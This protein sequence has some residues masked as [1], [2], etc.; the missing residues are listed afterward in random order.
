MI[1]HFGCQPAQSILIS[2]Q[3]V[4]LHFL[5]F[6]LLKKKSQGVRFSFTVLIKSDL[7]FWCF[8]CSASLQRRIIVCALLWHPKSLS[9]WGTAPKFVCSRGGA[10]SV[11]FLGCKPTPRPGCTHPGTFWGVSF[12]SWSSARW[13]ISCRAEI[14]AATWTGLFVAVSAISECRRPT[15]SAFC[16]AYS[17]Y[18]ADVCASAGWFSLLW[19]FSSCCS[20]TKAC[21]GFFIVWSLCIVEPGK[22]PV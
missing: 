6:V 12:P 2:M 17:Q 21:A 19:F 8:R 20:K 4:M 5:S 11:R 18:Q 7:R 14:F 9:G 10:L 13:W 15:S 16:C 22:H 3:W 1:Q